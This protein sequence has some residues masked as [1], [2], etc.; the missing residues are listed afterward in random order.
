MKKMKKIIALF[1][2]VAMITL[3]TSV[4]SAATVEEKKQSVRKAVEDTLDR[5]YKVQP[6]ARDAVESYAGY[7][8]F[9]DISTKLFI[10]GGSKGKGIAVNNN[11]KTE[12]FMRMAEVQFGLGFG[13]KEYSVIFVFET[14]DALNTFVH[15]GWEFGGQATLA[16]TDKV[17]G[18]SLQGAV[19]ASPGVWMYQLTTKGLAAEITA[20]G[21]RYYKDSD[22][23]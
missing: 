15:Q 20:K 6:D 12:I 22:L 23:K 11:D 19:S 4:A 16:A 18:G 17:N 1:M 7:A 8:V 14:E 2:M 9:N 5:L 13:I 3:M 10:T 21:T